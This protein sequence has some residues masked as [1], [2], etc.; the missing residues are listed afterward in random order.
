MRYS[1]ATFLCL[2]AINAQANVIQYITGISYSN[3]AELFKVKQNE[4]I[5]GATGFYTQGVFKGSALNFNTFQ[6]DSGISTTNRVSVLPYGRLATR[7]NDKLVFGV[8]VTQPIHSN[9]AWGQHSITRYASSANL[10]TDID[11]SPRASFSLSKNLYVGAGMNFNFLKNNESDWALPISP[12][13]YATLRNQSSW[14]DLGYNLGMYYLIDQTNFFGAA[15]FSYI[16]ENTHGPSTLAGNATNMRFDFN[17]PSTAV[18]TYVHLFNQ[19]W[20][21]SL[22]AIRSGWNINQFVYFKNTA[23]LPPS[24]VDYTFPMKFRSSW[25]YIAAVRHQLNEKTGLT[26]IGMIDDSPA[27]NELRTVNFPADTQYFLALVADYHVTKTSSFELLYGQGYSK[28]IISNTVNVNGQ[29][30]PLSPGRIKLQA[31]VVDLKF[32]IQM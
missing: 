1:L 16:N 23:S 32:K 17:I 21:T 27:R 20:L 6:Y 25:S 9:L 4:F 26:L 24:P 15:F 29:I 18:F 31:N 22:Q 7:Y 11:I 30:F 8:D 10:I 12:T 14:F 3:P 5:I 2:T 13:K 28:T 19:N